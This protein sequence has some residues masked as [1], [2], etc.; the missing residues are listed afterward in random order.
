MST[1]IKKVCVIGAG[2][3]G[4]GIAAHIANAGVPVLLLDI[5]APHAIDRSAIAKGAVAKMLKASPAPFMSSAAARLVATGNI[6]DDLAR[7]AECDWVVEAVVER[8]EV[9]RALYARLEAL[10]R[11]GTA[12]SSNTSTIPLAQL[13]AGRSEQ[14][15][16]DFLITHFFNPPR[17][18][19]L[20]EIATGPKTDSALAREIESFADRCLGK[21]VV[22]TR[23]TPGF[24]AN[25]I[26]S[27]WLTVGLTAA[28]DLGLTIEEADQIAGKPL[29]VPATGIFGLIDLVGLDLIP[30]LAQSLSSA[31]PRNDAYFEVLRPQPLIDKMIAAGFTGRKGKGGFYRLDTGSDGS[32]TRLAMDLV[33]GEYRASRK[34]HAL[35]SGAERDLATLVAAPGKTGAYARAVLYRVL[36]YAAALVG[37]IADDIVTIDR[38]MQLGY[39]WQ[40]GPFELIDRFGAERLVAGLRAEGRSVPALL[41]R[42]GKQS[43]YRVKDGVREHLT[44]Q[45]DYRPIERPTGVLLL[46]DIKRRSAPLL[47]NASAALWD[48]GDGVT[49]FEFTSKMNSLDEPIFDLLQQTLGLVQ[50]RF[51]ALVIYNEGENFSAGANLGVAMFAINIAAWSEVE[52]SI[53]VGQQTFKALK[54]APFPVVAAPAGLALGGG[55]EICLHADA[56]QAHAET[57]M[58]LVETGVGVI[59]GWGGCGELLDR[60][61]KAPGMPRGPMPA[62]MQAFKTISTAEVAKSA[63]EAR[64]LNFLR[65][66]DGITMNRDRLL[67]DAKARALALVEGYEPPAKPLFRLPGKSGFTGLIDAVREFRAKGLA[68]AYDEVIGTRL[69]AVLTGDNADIVDTLSEEQLLTLE[70]NAFIASVKDPRTQ[71]RI[72]QMLETG[73]PLRN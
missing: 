27:Y 14:F 45:G 51:K 52:R 42:V 72:E 73:K 11:P 5:V 16:R 50:Q 6:E 23:D 47:R 65:A 67:A 20:L 21:S 15:Q 57:Y 39:N 25:R 55:C 4:A 10:K 58:G 9:K 63:A 70:R 36:A 43:F 68:T 12:V 34:P 38:A 60:I 29:G 24:I 32:K 37:E 41:E 71:A 59:P 64:A 46:E 26:G 48:A 18:L 17:Y 35:P 62:V 54:Y 19:R 22:R 1:A 69:A 2:T 53:A 30:M 40:Y 66:A 7:V 13:V 49:V 44:L 61:A 31:L 28:A 3:M 56:I 33:S 8:L